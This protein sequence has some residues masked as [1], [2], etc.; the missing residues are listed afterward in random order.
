MPAVR[1]VVARA[2]A[3][4]G[5]G[6]ETCRLWSIDTCALL[7]S[8]PIC[9]ASA[10]RPIT[11]HTCGRQGAPGSYLLRCVLAGFGCYESISH[12]GAMPS[13]TRPAE[14][15]SYMLSLGFI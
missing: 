9:P 3:V 6:A 8:G 11:A 7:A 4:S 10:A 12:V 1:A 14:L 13:L 2:V 5:R 15:M